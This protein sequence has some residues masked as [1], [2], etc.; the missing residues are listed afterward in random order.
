MY[1][2]TILS[3]Y[4]PLSFPSSLVPMLAHSEINYDKDLQSYPF[5]TAY[6]PRKLA[7]AILQYY[8]GACFSRERRLG[9]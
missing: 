1:P 4:K 6:P 2:P 8:E 5:A 3:L 7:I 9:N